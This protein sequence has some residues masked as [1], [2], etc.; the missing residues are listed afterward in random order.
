MNK[1]GYCTTV[2]IDD[3]CIYGKG[4]KAP[5]H[6]TLIHIHV[7]VATDPKIFPKMTSHWY[8]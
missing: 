5:T 2:F 6:R 7:R 4:E 1:L 8:K 3:E